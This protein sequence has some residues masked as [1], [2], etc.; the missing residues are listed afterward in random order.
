MVCGY[1]LSSTSV[2]VPICVIFKGD[3][4]G[5]ECNIKI[6][7][8]PVIIYLNNGSEKYISQF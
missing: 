4:H 7:F 2:T 3:G 8:I 6:L 5:G 1:T